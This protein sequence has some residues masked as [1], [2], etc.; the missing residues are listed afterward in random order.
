[1]N[2]RVVEACSSDDRPSGLS[3]SCARL[4]DPSVIVNV[5]GEINRRRTDRG[6]GLS[7]SRAKLCVGDDRMLERTR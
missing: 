5:G 4:R 3:D 2:V 6:D 7:D 1:M